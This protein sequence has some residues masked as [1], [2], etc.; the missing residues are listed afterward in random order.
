VVA[1]EGTVCHERSEDD[2]VQGRFWDVF[3]MEAG[4]NKRLTSYLMMVP[5]DASTVD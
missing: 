4:K 5:T 3:D 2:P 1:V